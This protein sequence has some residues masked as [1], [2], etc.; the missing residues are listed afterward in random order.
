MKDWC[1]KWFLSYPDLELFK[2]KAELTE[3]DAV[4]Y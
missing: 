4:V 3:H 2:Q 1:E